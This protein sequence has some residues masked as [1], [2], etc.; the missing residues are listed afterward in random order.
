VGAFKQRLGTGIVSS[1]VG[2]ALVTGTLLTPAMNQMGRALADTSCVGTKCTSTTT[3]TITPGTP[4]TATPPPGCNPKICPPPLN[5]VVQTTPGKTSPLSGDSISIKI[6]SNGTIDITVT[7]QNG[8]PV[9]NFNGASITFPPVAG[10]ALQEFVKGHWVTVTSITGNGIY[11]LLTVPPASTPSIGKN[12]FV[13]PLPGSLSTLICPSC[14]RPVRVVIPKPSRGATATNSIQKGDKVSFT[15]NSDG[16]FSV[17]VTLPGK[18]GTLKGWSKSPITL[19]NLP[20]GAKLQVLVH[21][22]WVTVTSITGPGP[23]RIVP[24]PAPKKKK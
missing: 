9:T 19:P 3:G 14:N 24:P 21:G 16:S 17:G 10:R 12:G 8:N 11:R 6:N 18:K 13:G 7:D 2:V 5:L 15:Y 22:K 23:Y 20:K 4:I 1:L